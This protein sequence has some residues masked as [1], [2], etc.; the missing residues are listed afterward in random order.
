MCDSLVYRSSCIRNSLILMTCKSHE[1]LNI[2]G[3]SVACEAHVVLQNLSPTLFILF[4][5][6]RGSDI[7]RNKEIMIEQISFL[8]IVEMFSSASKFH[9]ELARRSLQGFHCL[10]KH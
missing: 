9:E 4:S 6:R 2:P 1:E 10:V 3:L 8:L 5:S 7:Y